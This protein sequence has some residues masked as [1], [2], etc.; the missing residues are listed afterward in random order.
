MRINL[1]QPVF[2]WLFIVL[3]VAVFI[4]LALLVVL[5]SLDS[6]QKMASIAEFEL[7]KRASQEVD[8]FL[9]K[10]TALV[11]QAASMDSQALRRRALEILIN[12]NAELKYYSAFS[13]SGRVLYQSAPRRE[14]ER[15]ILAISSQKIEE[16]LKN[17]SAISKVYR[18]ENGEPLV[19]VLVPTQNPPEIF[20]A[21]LN[22]TALWNSLSSLR[23]RESDLVYLVDSDGALLAHPNSSLVL[24]DI[25]L[26]NTAVVRRVL[27]SEEIKGVEIISDGFFKDRQVLISSSG[28]ELAP[29]KIIVESPS[30]D[31]FVVRDR[32]VTF[33]IILVVAGSI[34][35][36]LLFR[37]SAHLLGTTRALK[38]EK[39]HVSVI[40]N[41]LADGIIEYG[42][43][44]KIRLMNPKAEEL[45]GLKGDKI[46]GVDFSNAVEPKTKNLFQVISLPSSTGKKPHILEN[47]G[48]KIYL[49]ISTLEIGRGKDR[50][51]IK[52]LHDVSRDIFLTK[53]KSEFISVAAHQLRTP[54]AAVK[55]TI[56]MLLDEEAGALEPKQKDFLKKTYEANEHMIKLVNDLLDASRIEEGRFGYE[57]KMTDFLEVLGGVIKSLEGIVSKR[58][59]KL[60]VKAPRVRI[61]PF[62]FDVQRIQIVLSNLLENAV[63]YTKPGGLVTVE[64][65]VKG[66]FLEISVA[67]TGVGIPEDQRA[68]IF[69]KFFRADNVTRLQTEG[70]GLGLFISRNIV[71][72]HGGELSFTSEVNKGSRFV[73]TLPLS[74]EYIPEEENKPLTTFLNAV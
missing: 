71:R 61:P 17:G 37:N 20:A 65:D 36:V 63:R 33:A 39:D 43:D 52:V 4:F 48:E 18:S 3:S 73:F 9:R 27:D 1:H 62:T 60:E 26:G 31:I 50:A 57:F 67:D 10:N 22:L 66:A 23:I 13:V 44:L 74:K 58:L 24:A 51:F 41:V 56:K 64:L 2:I 6:I 25:S 54:L 28:H 16:A 11:K 8:G 70:S 12:N 40:V 7:A 14:A 45:F 29:W 68:R 49:E 38:S 46:K 5:P 47:A 15:E 59:I 42:P 55:W 32:V 21:T 34:L 19:S 69:T 35:L 53:V 30:R 72:R